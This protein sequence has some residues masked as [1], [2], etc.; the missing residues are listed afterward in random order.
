MDLQPIHKYSGH[1]QLLRFLVY[2]KY[3]RIQ[4]EDIE[5]RREGTVTKFNLKWNTRGLGLLSLWDR[6]HGE[7][8]LT[9]AQLMPGVCHAS[10]PPLTGTFRRRYGGVLVESF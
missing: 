3:R 10:D 7:V 4:S 2:Y 8:L 9:D 1:L 5:V 6:N